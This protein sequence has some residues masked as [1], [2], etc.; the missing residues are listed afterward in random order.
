[1]IQELDKKI[2]AYGLAEKKILLD[3]Q[4]SVPPDYMY[5]N[6]QIFY[7]LLLNCFEKYH[8]I[9]TIT[10]MKEN[11]NIWSEE[12]T[13]IYVESAGLYVDIREFPHDLEKLKIRYNEQILLLFGKS[14][15]QKNWNRKNFNDLEAANVAVKKVASEIDSIYKNKIFREGS[16]SETANEAKSRYQNIKENPELAK[17]I[18]LGLREF[19]RIT[20]GLQQSELMLIGGESSAG[21]SALAMNM[22]INAWLGSNKNNLSN[23]VNDGCNILLFSIEMPYEPMRRRCDACISGVPLYGIRDGNLTDKEED[24]FFAALEFQEKY[25]KQFHIL[26]IPRGC[27]MSVIESKFI[28]KCHEYTPDLILV[29][30]ISLMKPDKEQGSDWLNLGRLAEQMH[31]FCRTHGVPV[32]SPVQ[33]NRPKAGNKNGDFD[34]PDQHRV[35][36]SIMLTQNANILLNIETRKDEELRSDMVIK[37]AK[38]RDGEKGAFVLHKRLDLMRLY[39]DVPEWTPEIY[40]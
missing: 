21:K 3:L 13:E 39:D 12:M 8:E 4:T 38:M 36:R 30:Y 19:D 20:N 24:K 14:V 9:P 6:T 17:G 26:D 34:T 5:P 16:L 22:A 7:K 35:G 33:L 23:I 32:I 31:E 37:I 25:E 27:T 10:V 2:L 18:H 11:T 1:M 40:D 15:F 29:D 28:D